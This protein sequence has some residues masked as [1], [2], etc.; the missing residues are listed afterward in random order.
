MIKFSINKEDYCL[1]FYYS[2]IDHPRVENLQNTQTTCKMFKGKDVIAEGSVKQDSRDS[3]V[4]AKGRKAALAK[5]L[6]KFEEE[7]FRKQIWIAYFSKVR[8]GKY[9]LGNFSTLK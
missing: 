8:E 7:S 6:K 1:K 2:K 9:I 5:A 3:F 4:K